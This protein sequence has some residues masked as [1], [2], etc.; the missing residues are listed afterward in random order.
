VDSLYSLCERNVPA[1]P[2]AAEM[3]V[4]VLAALALLLGGGAAA[5]KAEQDWDRRAWLGKLERLKGELHRLTPSDADARLAAL[6]PAPTPPRQDKI[7]HFVVLFMEN[8]ATDV[9]TGCMERPGLDNIRNAKIPK[10]PSNPSGGSYTFKCHKEYV[11]AEGPKYS[12]AYIF[13]ATNVTGPHTESDSVVDVFGPDQIPVKVSISEQFAMFNRLYS[14][15]P[16]ASSPN[17]KFRP[18]RWRCLGPVFCAQS[19]T[20]FPP[21]TPR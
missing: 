16:A 6:A 8:Q 11:C 17:R 1:S 12:P 2:P 3:P 5:A 7:D 20:G 13:G 10:D 18:P 19:T 4:M 21:L 9:F 15:V 14:S